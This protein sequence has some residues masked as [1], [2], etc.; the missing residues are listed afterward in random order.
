MSSLVRNLK[1]KAIEPE[2]FEGQLNKIDGWIYSLE[3]YFIAN[4]LD[5]N[6]THEVECAAIAAALLRGVALN[7]HKRLS[8]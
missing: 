2:V 7:W 6:K 5:F 8:R 4:S 1:I 3:L